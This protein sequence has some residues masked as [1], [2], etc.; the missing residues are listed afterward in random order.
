MK[1]LKELKGKL[2]KRFLNVDW[3]KFVICYNCGNKGYIKKECCLKK[4]E[5][6]F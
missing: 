5:N 1:E 3:K 4:N 2:E 6:L